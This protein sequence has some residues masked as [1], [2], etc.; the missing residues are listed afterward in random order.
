MP[1]ELSINTRD[2]RNLI[3]GDVKGDQIRRDKVA[4][5]K[6]AGNSGMAAMTI[7]CAPMRPR[8]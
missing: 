5:N 6:V 7:L 2:V 4:G 8:I 1:A 3:N